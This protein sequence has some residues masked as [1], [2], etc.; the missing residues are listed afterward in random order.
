MPERTPER[1]RVRV[2]SLSSE[3]MMR[4]RQR[5]GGEPSLELVNA[6][7]AES[8]RIRRQQTLYKLINGSFHK[9]EFLGEHWHHGAGLILLINERQRTAVTVIT[10]DDEYPKNPR[11][12]REI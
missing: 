8:K 12:P 7:L 11:P 2:C 6:L 10:P 9:Y 4:Y 1:D 5:F 3:F